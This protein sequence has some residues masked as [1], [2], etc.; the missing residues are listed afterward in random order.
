M[1]SESG[2]TIKHICDV[3]TISRPTFYR[4]KQNRENLDSNRELRKIIN[5]IA[6]EF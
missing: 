5:E 1:I 2:F 3:D 4:W 6:L